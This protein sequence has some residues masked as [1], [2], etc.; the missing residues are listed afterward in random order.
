MIIGQEQDVLGGMFSQSESFM[1]KMAYIDI[2]SKALSSVEI[3]K[4][5]N[6][7]NETF[8]GDLYAWPEMQDNVKGGVE[9]C[10]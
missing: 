8:V 7:C 2:W 5:L 9:V 3:L 4:H 6:D 1:G 10:I